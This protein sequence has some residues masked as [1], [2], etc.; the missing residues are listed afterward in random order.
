[1]QCGPIH[2]RCSIELP[3]GHVGSCMVKKRLTQPLHG[4]PPA[5]LLK[6]LTARPSNP[7]F[8]PNYDTR[9]QKLGHRIISLRGPAAQLGNWRSPN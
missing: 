3:R 8:R 2:D 1:L 6:F 9:S 4:M 5:Q 7:A